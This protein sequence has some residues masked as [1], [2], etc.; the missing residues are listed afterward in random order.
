MKRSGYFVTVEV[1][2]R[3]GRDVATVFDA[4]QKLAYDSERES[5]CLLF[6]AYQDGS[7]PSR[8]IL[9]ER[10]ESEGA[11]KQHASEAHSQAFNALGLVE[12][13]RVSKSVS[14]TR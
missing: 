2:A 11:F 7:E 8:F 9:W 12:L 4:L 13:V 10:F 5:G 3:Q 14:T 6:T 1:Q